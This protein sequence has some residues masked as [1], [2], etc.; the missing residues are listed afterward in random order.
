[1]SFLPVLFLN[2]LRSSTASSTKG[3]TGLEVRDSMLCL[4]ALRL[5]FDHKVISVW[6]NMPVMSWVAGLT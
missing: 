3:T 6:P 1:M 2:V 5:I 4:F